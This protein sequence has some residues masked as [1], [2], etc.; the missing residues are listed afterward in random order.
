M[1]DQMRRNDKLQSLTASASRA[2]ARA[3]D[4]AAQEAQ[5]REAESNLQQDAQARQAN[6]ADDTGQYD[7]AARSNR[8][9]QASQPG[10]TSYSDRTGEPYGDS[11]ASGA[12]QSRR[13]RRASQS[14]QGRHARGQHAP[15]SNTRTRQIP[16]DN[17]GR[18]SLVD[19]F[20]QNVVGILSVTAV[21]VLVVLMVFFVRA[22]APD[23]QPD[24]TKGSSQEAPAYVSPYD[25]DK[26]DRTN[27]RFA[28]VV[29]GQ[30]K[31]RIGIDVSDNQHEIDWN[32]VAADGIDFAMIRLGYRGATEGDLYLDGYYYDNLSGAKDAGVDCG[33]YFFSQAVNVAEAEEE[34]DFVLSNLG[35]TP[36][37]YPIAFDSEIVH[38]LDVKRTADLSNDEMTA[39]ANAFMNRVEQAGYRCLLY[40]NAAD[41]ARY[42]DDLVKQHAVWWAEYGP[43]QPNAQTD[44]VMWQYANDGAVAGIETAVDMNIDLSGALS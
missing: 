42:N 13:P 23:E 21:V 34:A 9:G 20:K 30:V 2:R 43:A 12:T 17:Q 28:Y 44:I 29:D 36:L 7:R 35:G 24:T 39:I 3:L 8:A 19:F 37:E 5:G 32:A 33:I 22:C 38:G 27:G 16:E 11:R 25:W 15:V 31:S 4:N 14:A 10:Q 40:G 18:F 41:L 1:S 26:L 6:W